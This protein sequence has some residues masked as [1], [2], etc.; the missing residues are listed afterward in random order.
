[1]P[2]PTASSTPQA[3]A[4]IISNPDRVRTFAGSGNFSEGSASNAGFNSPAG[5]AWD[6]SGNLY[7]ADS[8]G[9]RIRKI[10]PAGIVTTLAGNGEVG[11]E[12]GTGAAARFNHPVGVA[13]DNNANELVVADFDNRAVRRVTLSGQVSTLAWFFQ[14]PTGIAVDSAGNT[15]LADSG[16][17]EIRKISPLGEVSTLAGGSQGY[18]DA[19][20]SAAR[21]DRPTQLAMGPG[22]NLFVADLNNNRIRK[23]APDGTVTTYAGGNTSAENG[24]ALQVA[25]YGPQ[26][27]AADTAGNL[28][29]SCHS[30]RSLRKIDTGGNATVIAGPTG[31]SGFFDGSALQA[32]FNWE[33][34]AAPL[35]ADDQGN[36][37]I[38]DPINGRVRMLDIT[39]NVS[40]LA[41][42]NRR[43]GPA[44]TA[45]FGSVGDL[46]FDGAG[47]LIVVDAWNQTLRKVAA[48][49]D[50]ATLAGSR[51]GYQDGKG[52]DTRFLF[53]LSR[54]GVV[55][56]GQGNIILTDGDN[57][58]LRKVA[59]DGTVTTFAG[60]GQQALTDGA[61]L[62]A[63]FN[64]PEAITR[65]AGGN[66]YVADQNAKAIRKITPG[67]IVSTLVPSSN[68]AFGKVAGLA[69]APDGTLY[70]ADEDQHVIHKIAPD[71]NITVAA[72][73]GTAGTSDGPAA[74]AK[75]NSPTDVALDPSGNLYFTEGASHLV[76]RLAKNGT[77]STV[78]GAGIQGFQD[79]QGASARF[80]SPQHLAVAPDGRVYVSD[81]A[82]WRIRVIE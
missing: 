17:H 76:R 14:S 59:P 79:S 30:D 67:G 7:V 48:N 32:Q 55:S 60:S 24:P 13:F 38:A 12:D 62:A 45:R 23:V 31:L 71:G 69:A 49:G 37:F 73:T 36:L 29:V 1:M 57:H 74:S 39:G 81:Q 22:G 20:G 64:R 52:A 10:S 54:P 27:V 26:G 34:P 44:G 63:A 18:V 70:A 78:A 35:A 40:T 3:I 51:A 11:T 9:N 46:A 77:V 41:G 50:V 82:N 65:D 68:T 42:D 4:T 53:T 66:L 56:D 25:L 72:G 15:Y 16:T 8:R 6:G 61:A 75:L 19:K 47:N 28:Y 58:R 33:W 21:F 2:S 5:L 80:N 43:D